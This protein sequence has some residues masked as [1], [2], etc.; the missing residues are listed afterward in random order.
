MEDRKPKTQDYFGNNIVKYEL[1]QT[2]QKITTPAQESSFNFANYLNIS[3]GIKLP[4]NKQRQAVIIAPYFKYSL[5]P[6]TQK[7]IDFNSGGVHLRYNFSFS[8][9]N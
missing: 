8:K 7:Q 2:N 9:N 3:L 1:V 4:V 5:K 6:L